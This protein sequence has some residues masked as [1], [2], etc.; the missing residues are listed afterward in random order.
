M[1]NEYQPT[2]RLTDLEPPDP[3]E[4]R[5]REL[6]QYHADTRPQSAAPLPWERALE[7]ARAEAAFEATNYR[8]HIPAENEAAFKQAVEGANVFEVPAGTRPQSLAYL[9]LLKDAWQL[10]LAKSAGYSGHS[11][12]VWANFRTKHLGVDDERSIL[13]R[14][15]DKWQRLL[16]LMTNEDNDK[17]G[18]SIDDLHRD[19]AAYHLIALCIRAERKKAEHGGGW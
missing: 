3:I 13:V 10:H 18:E 12:D 2:L 4:R 14:L 19:A 6:M 11:E 16:S 17:V 7:L 1:T 8:R 5:A 9:A 15:N